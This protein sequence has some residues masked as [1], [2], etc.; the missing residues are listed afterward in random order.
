[1][2]LGTKSR[3]SGVNQTNRITGL[4]NENLSQLD[5]VS[6]IVELLCEIDHLVAR[7]LLVAWPCSGQKGAECS[8]GDRVALLSASCSVLQ[9]SRI[10]SEYSPN[11]GC[12]RNKRTQAA[13]HF[14]V[15]ALM[16]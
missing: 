14:W 1:M 2:V 8:H 15:E 9:K 7:I 4:L 5:H 6:V 12:R 16:T 10:R 13:S 11:V 3:E